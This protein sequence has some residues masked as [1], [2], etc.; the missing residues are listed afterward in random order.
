VA[1]LVGYLRVSHVGVREPDRFH[2][3]EEQ[4]EEIEGWA[5][6]EGHHVEFLPPE[7]DG[8]GGDPTRPILRQ[9]IESVKSKQYAGVVVAYLSRA[10]RDL[11]L[12]LDLWDEVEAKDVGGVVYFAREKIDGSTSSG[13]LQRNLLAS[14]AQHEVEERRDGFERATAGAVERGIWQRRQT[15]RGYDKD[16][17]TRRL[18]VN[19][20]AESVR[21]AADA[22]LKGVP[23]VRIGEQLRMTAGGVRAMLR[24]R[25]YLGELKVRSY[26][27][28]EAHDPILEPGT[29][30]AVQ[31]KLAAAS[32]PARSANETMLLA[33]LVRCASCGHVMTRGRSHQDLVYRCPVNHSGERCPKPTAISCK[34][35]EPYVE[36]VALG[37]LGRMSVK[38]SAASGVEEAQEAVAGAEAELSAYLQ[39]VDMAGIS[40]PDAAAGMRSR[41][42]KVDDARERLR[43]A[44]A[45]TPSLPVIE[46]G[47]E[48][49]ETLNSSERNELLRGLLAAVAV[50]AVGAGARVEVADRVRIFRFGA[51]I[52]LPRGR[53]GSASGIVPLP[54][55]DID[56]VD[57][58]GVPSAENPL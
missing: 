54:W 32:R 43:Q 24:N 19:G 6:A 12:M 42:E 21:E 28:S 17:E 13:R 56:G 22:F 39:A 10:G 46:G 9:A 7:L 8:K 52:K 23:L 16:A 40:A 44:L 27:N 53:T 3:P 45:R 25:V 4:T 35:I 55:P 48:V 26:V 29:F 58:I 15:P 41:R 20:D 38:A 37:E 31:A 33:G 57:V 50:R 11:R 49:W 30:E 36:E 5:K 47:A 2:S 14:I 51:N 18:I 34:R 1:L